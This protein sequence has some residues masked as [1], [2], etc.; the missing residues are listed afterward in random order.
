MVVEA[1]YAVGVNEPE[2]ALEVEPPPSD[3]DGSGV[4]LSLVRWSVSLT[5]LERLT[6]AEELINEILAIRERNAKS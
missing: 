1:R 4:D 3:Y 6:S 5:P 2:A